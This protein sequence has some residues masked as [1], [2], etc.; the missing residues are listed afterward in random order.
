M[1]TD[2]AVKH[3]GSRK[4]LADALGIWPQGVYLWGE[5]PP[6][7]RQYEIEVRTGGALRADRDDD[8]GTDVAA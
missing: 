6:M 5:R 7:S 1:T 2:E 3:Y 8:R 4:A